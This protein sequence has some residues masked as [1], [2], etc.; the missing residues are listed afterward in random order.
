MTQRVV[1]V[2]K[3]LKRPHSVIMH[4]A[5]FEAFGIDARYELAEIDESELPSI[6]ERAQ[7]EG[8]LGIQITAPYKRAVMPFLDLVEPAA[9]QIGAV[10]SVEVTADGGL[11]GFNTDTLGFVAGVRSGLEFEISG[12]R[13]VV[14]GSGGVGHAVV[15]GLISSGA[16][17]VTV[18]DMTIDMVE[19]LARDLADVGT[20]EGM[21]LDDPRLMQRLTGADLFVNATSVGMISP[22]PVL[23]VEAL[24]PD[25]AVFDVVYIPPQTELVRQAGDAGHRASNGLGMLVA[26]AAAA[27]VRWT[28]CPDPSDIMRKALDEQLDFDD[29]RP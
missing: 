26:Q 24:S 11:I 6:T 12:A 18:A 4:N 13:T 15:H 25:C 8:W 19:Q 5:A 20:F 1:L 2:G 17:E 9:R 10:N 29:L 3:P 23:P 7:A 27:F 14:A 28:G 16:A 22:G 21:Q